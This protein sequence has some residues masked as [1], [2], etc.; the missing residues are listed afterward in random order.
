MGD[1]NSAAP[2]WACIVGLNDVNAM[3]KRSVERLTARIIGCK[4]T[5]P[6]DSGAPEWVV[7]TLPEG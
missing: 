2:R 3:L 5:S 7:F 1:D 4:A 6:S